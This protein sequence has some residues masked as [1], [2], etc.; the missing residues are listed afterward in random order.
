MLVLGGAPVSRFAGGTRPPQTR[1]FDLS[2]V[3]ADRRAFLRTVHTELYL[4][5]QLRNALD[6]RR[7]A[8][9]QGWE[10]CVE[11]HGLEVTIT[12]GIPLEVDR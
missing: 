6:Q 3:T 11:Q 9:V 4:Q 10:A 8:F 2:D 1:R 12:D 5:R 7:R